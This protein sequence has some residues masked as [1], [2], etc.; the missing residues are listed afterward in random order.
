MEIK[1]IALMV[2][3]ILPF[4]LYSC[5]G[6]QKNIENYTDSTQVDAENSTQMD[7]VNENKISLTIKGHQINDKTDFVFETSDFK[8]KTSSFTYKNDTTAIIK[9][10]NYAQ[11]DVAGNRTAD[12]ID[13]NVELHAKNGNVLKATSYPY[14]KWHNDFWSKVYIMTNE[15]SVWFN[16][17]SGMPHQGDVNIR[18]ID[19]NNICG[20]FNLNVEKPENSTIG[21]VR[22]N[23]TF[24]ILK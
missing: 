7:C 5:G 18:F 22:L 17:V 14:Q 11:E 13:I 9:L 20:T 23:G 15:G 4:I 16:W 10:S 3:T 19:K 24:S 6:G 21:I 1:K 8:V 12:Q 2:I